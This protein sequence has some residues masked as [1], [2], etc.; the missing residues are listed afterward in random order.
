MTEENS[1]TKIY[2]QGLVSV[3]V[4]EKK[5]LPTAYTFQKSYKVDGEWKYTNNLNL[6]DLYIVQK[7]I[8][9]I[10]SEN[11]KVYDNK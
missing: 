11:I 5:D 8:A 2:K 3:S 10:T 6:I 4:W 7:I 1:P 9:K